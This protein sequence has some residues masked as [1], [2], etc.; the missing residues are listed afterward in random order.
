MKII[1]LDE[2]NIKE[3]MISCLKCTCH[4]IALHFGN[5]WTG[6]RSVPSPFLF[7]TAQ[8]LVSTKPFWNGF[9]F[10]FSTVC[11]SPAI[12]VKMSEYGTDP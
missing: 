7:S 8:F 6:T 3:I 11:I 2:T 4:L 5:F 9:Q 12:G 1:R 10:V